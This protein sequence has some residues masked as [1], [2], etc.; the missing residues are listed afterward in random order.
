MALPMILILAVLLAAGTIVESHFSTVVA[1][2]FVYGT[3]WFGGFLILLSINLLCSALSRFPWKKYQT[4][5]VITHLGI[6]TILAGSMVTQQM[7]ADGQI[8]LTEGEEGHIFQEDK[9]NFYYQI[10]EGPIEQV[11]ASFS[12]RPPNPDH[13]LLVNLPEGGILMV[14]Q[15]YL[16]AQKKV[17]G[18]VAGEGEKGFPAVHVNLDSSFVHENQWLFL[19]HADYGHLDLGPASVFFEKE[20]DWKK[21]LAMGAKE[22]SENALAFLLEKDGSLKYQ[23]RH[24]GEFT[25]V[26][27][28]KVGQDYSTGW[29]DMQFKAEERLSNALP[30]ET[31]L[32]Q[33]LP[34]QKDPESAIHYELIQNPDKKEGWLG[35]Q[36]QTTFHLKGKTFGLAYG[37]KQIR[38]P[39]TLHLTKFKLGLDPGT[40]KPAS[41]ASEIL[42]TDPEKG[43]Q[44]PAEISMNQPLHFKGYTVYQASYQPMPDGKYI[45]V[46]SVGR[47][48][49]I[50]IKYTGAIT[51]VLGIIFM[52]WFKN[53][54]WGKK[55]TNEN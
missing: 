53:P 13:P 23:T 19:G 17:A 50:W 26:Q 44:V 43:T 18:R 31:Y 34:N 7:G 1:K 51:L 55:E 25:P 16:N 37:P 38:L 12:F 27:P 48:P 32:E 47:D 49:G 22:V 8:A 14:D 46:F 4:G 21:R 42:Y 35:Y 45:S 41:Y 52:F 5:F 28:L 29:M 11:P 24:R 40:D 15:F 2:R 36:G 9:P 33:P 10:G 30:E 6:I 39:F 54:S 20:A 3:W